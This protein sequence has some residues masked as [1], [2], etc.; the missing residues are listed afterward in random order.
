MINAPCPYLERF[1][2][3]DLDD[4]AGVVPHHVGRLEFPG[5]LL[6]LHQVVRVAER[7]HAQLDTMSDKLCATTEAHLLL[8][9]R[10]KF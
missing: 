8:T 4:A 6:H 3:F 2:E 9:A 5:L 7:L 10:N 1:V